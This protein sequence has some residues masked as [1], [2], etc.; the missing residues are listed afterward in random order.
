MA[1]VNPTK[2]QLNT[3]RRPS[4]RGLLRNDDV[5]YKRHL[6]IKRYTT[7]C[8]CLLMVFRGK[9][10]ILRVK[11]GEIV[12]FFKILED[13]FLEFSFRKYSKQIFFCFNQGT[14]IMFQ[15][16]NNFKVSI[17]Q[18]RKFSTEYRSRSS[19][20][21]GK[22]SCAAESSFSRMKCLIPGPNVKSKQKHL[23][24]R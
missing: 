4:P 24:S 2:K 7:A 5:Q 12:P 14:I 20:L 6:L 23:Q 16:K 13:I 19:N 18:P 3:I 22:N 1:N 10:L 9:L 8:L 17:F 21:N 15:P 11:G